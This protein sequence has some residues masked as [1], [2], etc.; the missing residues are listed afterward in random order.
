MLRTVRENDMQFVRGT[1][2]LL[3]SLSGIGEQITL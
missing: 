3:L 2:P 1:Q